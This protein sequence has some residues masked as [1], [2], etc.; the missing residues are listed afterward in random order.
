VTSSPPGPSPYSPQGSDE[1]IWRRPAAGG[2]QG[3]PPPVSAPPARPYT[4]PPPT[5]PPRPGWRPRVLVQVPEARMLPAQ[6]D[7][8]MDEQDRSART[9][10]Y[11]IG[12][13]A[14]AIALIVM[15]VLCGRVLF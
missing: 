8:E 6:D 7:T 9:I 1:Q 4:G 14:G 5:I 11:G 12:M 15:F 10:T 3:P 13:M 2:Q